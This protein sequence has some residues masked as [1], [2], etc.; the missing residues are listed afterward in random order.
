MLWPAC[1]LKSESESKQELSIDLAQLKEA[2]QRLEAQVRPTCRIV[3]D[4]C[5]LW[6]CEAQPFTGR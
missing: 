5:S 1:R 3:G 6:V 2:K 4:G